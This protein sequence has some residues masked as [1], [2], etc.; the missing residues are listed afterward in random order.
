MT[1]YYDK[2]SNLL[3]SNR[4]KIVRAFQK[5]LSASSLPN[6][7]CVISNDLSYTQI[8]SSY[9]STVSKSA[10]ALNSDPLALETQKYDDL[11]SVTPFGVELDSK[12]DAVSSDA[13]DIPKEGIQN[14]ERVVVGVLGLEEAEKMLGFY[15][16]AQLVYDRDIPVDVATKKWMMSQG[17]ALEFFR[18]ATQVQ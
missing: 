1:A 8:A 13:Y 10:K 4:F 12:L 15:Q 2:E 6:T 5:L 11:T 9:L 7:A 18:C 17:N 3:S 16:S 14:P